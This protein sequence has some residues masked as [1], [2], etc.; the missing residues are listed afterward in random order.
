M[1]TADISGRITAEDVVEAIVLLIE[2]IIPPDELGG[3]ALNLILDD[4]SWSG[5]IRTRFPLDWATYIHPEEVE[6]D[7]IGDS[8]GIPRETGFTVNVVLDIDR[9]LVSDV[10]IISDIMIA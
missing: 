2:D 1:N 5:K 7:T 8:V 4:S 9:V 6:I 10:K 3:I